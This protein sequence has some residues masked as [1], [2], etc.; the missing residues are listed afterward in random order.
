MLGLAT[1]R[2][3]LLGSEGPGDS[4]RTYK[5]HAMESLN[6]VLASL[7]CPEY[8]ISMLGWLLTDWKDERQPECSFAGRNHCCL[9]D[10]EEGAFLLAQAPHQLVES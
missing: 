9:T 3:S 4:W 5:K 1:S 2:L 6:Q 10:L 8:T 7:V